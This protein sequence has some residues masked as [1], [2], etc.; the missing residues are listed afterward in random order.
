M[1]ALMLGRRGFG[2]RHD[3]KALWL[4]QYESWPGPIELDDRQGGRLWTWL[5]LAW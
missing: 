3:E 2:W 4:L 5:L 1:S